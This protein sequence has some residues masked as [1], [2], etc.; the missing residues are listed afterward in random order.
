MRTRNPNHISV[1]LVLAIVLLGLAWIAV[2]KFAI[3]A[4][5][6]SAY[7]GES[8]PILNRMIRGQAFH[9]LAEYLVPWA[10]LKWTILLFLFVVGLLIVWIARPEF[11]A[12]FWRPT[13]RPPEDPSA[14]VKSMAKHRLFL[15]YAL[16]AVIVGGSLFD[17]IRDSEHWPFSQYPMYSETLTSRSFTWFRLLGVMQGGTEI[18]LHDNRYLQPFDNS[19]LEDALQHAFDKH[20][21]KEAVL[22]CFVRYEALRRAGRHNGPQLQAM[23]LYR[24]YW[25]L[26]PW[27]RNIDHPDRMDFLVEVRQSEATEP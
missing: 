14:G 1:A 24:L 18:Q 22:D 23:R 7:R 25:V 16:G 3:P 5:I 12:A 6:A 10:H 15:V 20:Q 17:L 19:R 9:P 13:A 27:A 4:M 11:R 2:A 26:D 8:W 21:L